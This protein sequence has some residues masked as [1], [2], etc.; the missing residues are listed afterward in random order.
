ML[1][2]A[3]GVLL[4]VRPHRH[5]CLI[6][7]FPMLCALLLDSQAAGK[8]QYAHLCEP[9]LGLLFLFRPTLYA[10]WSN[11]TVVCILRSLPFASLGDGAK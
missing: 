5:S 9:A 2:R 7:D 6:F 11:T 8:S 4:S 3:A 10:S 1:L